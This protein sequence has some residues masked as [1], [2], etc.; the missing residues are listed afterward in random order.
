MKIQKTAT[1]NFRGPNN[2]LIN[3]EGAGKKRLRQ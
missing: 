3:S 1:K 2:Q